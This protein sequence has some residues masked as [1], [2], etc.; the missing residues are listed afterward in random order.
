MCRSPIKYMNVLYS[1]MGNV[2]VAQKIFQHLDYV[3]LRINLTSG[4][5]LAYTV[6][7]VALILKRLQHQLPNFCSRLGFFL[8]YSTLTE[9]EV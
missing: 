2:T 4:S 3:I 1:K 9:N 6:Q 5:L 8:F 7:M